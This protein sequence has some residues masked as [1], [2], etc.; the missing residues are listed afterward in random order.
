[1]I[2][3]AAAGANLAV[4]R[5]E[6]DHVVIDNEVEAIRGWRIDQIYTS[7]LFGLKSARPPELDELLAKRKAI[8]SRRTLSEAD[9][10]E[11]AQ[12]EAEIGDLPTGETADQVKSMA[13]IEQPLELLKNRQP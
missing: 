13:L 1:L 9:K 3:Q 10:R 12:L 4:L 11:L 5:R 8:L 7:D 6:G 2:V